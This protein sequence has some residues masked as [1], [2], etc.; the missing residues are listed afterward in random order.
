MEELL[1]WGAILGFYLWSAYKSNQKK[2]QAIKPQQ[3][4]VKQKV[5]SPQIP[6][7]QK[8]NIMDF[9]NEAFEETTSKKEVVFTASKS[10]KEKPVVSNQAHE[11]QNKFKNH[12]DGQHDLSAIDDRHLDKLDLKDKHLG[13]IKSRLVNK[14]KNNQR[15]RSSATLMTIQKK[16]RKNPTEL[17]IIM[18]AV[19]EPPKAMQ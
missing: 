9:L 16:Y 8:I 5:D 7:N 6:S 17:G 11:V 12:F 1:Y 10:K 13:M 14:P 18:Q 4:P 19:F 3:S 2:A 15:R